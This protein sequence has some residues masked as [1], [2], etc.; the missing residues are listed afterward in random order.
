MMRIAFL[1]LGQMGSAIASR[2]AHGKYEVTVWNRTAAAAQPLVAHGAKS[3]SSAAE[4]VRDADVVLT[5]LLN[6]AALE[7]VLFE[8][9]V[10]DALPSGA[11]HVSL[12]TISVALAERLEE[13][14]HTRGQHLVGAPVFGRPN[15]A[16]EG[17]LWIAAAGESGPL[18][19][20]RPVLESFSRGKTVV[21]ER[22][23]LAHAVKIGGNFLITAMIASLSEGITFAEAHNLEAGVYLE[24]I[25][26]A[27]F[28][29]PF[30]AAYSKV[31]LHP[32]EQVAATVK[33]GQK[34][35]RLFQQAAHTTHTPVPL[36]DLF[37]QQ[38]QAAI[39]G[40]AGERDWA[41]GYLQQ[42]RA[43]TETTEKA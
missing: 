31:M 40:G 12:S 23:S 39:E 29:S 41:A 22:A 16:H 7:S 38:F 33:L 6:D 15:V 4:A 35:M 19:T 8:Q 36:A 2:I 9:G 42:I 5:M 26:S 32:P 27:I 14:H 37:E 11:V 28:Q 13:E 1:G 24:V 34:D 20:V 3:A 25:N 10:M 21:G 17:K 43:Q 18:S 30:Y